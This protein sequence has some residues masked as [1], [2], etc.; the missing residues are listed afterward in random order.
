MSKE[1]EAIGHLNAENRYGL[2]PADWGAAGSQKDWV[3]I[4]KWYLYKT[5]KCAECRC[6]IT[7]NLFEHILTSSKR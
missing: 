1:W 6:E 4:W 3:C 7:Q 2:V 5:E